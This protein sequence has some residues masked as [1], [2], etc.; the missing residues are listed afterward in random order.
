MAGLK[1]GQPVFHGPI[2][3]QEHDQ[4]QNQAD[5]DAGIQIGRLLVGKTQPFRFN[6][7][8]AVEGDPQG[9]DDAQAEQVLQQVEGRSK[10]FPQKLPVGKAMIKTD[11]KGLHAADGDDQETPKDEEVSPAGR[12]SDYPPLP[13]DKGG[14]AL[15]TP[16]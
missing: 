11:P 6:H 7:K 16:A 14:H 10:G 4:H 5:D 9:G 13:Q 1:L 2:G 12:F 8:T 15:E 3:E